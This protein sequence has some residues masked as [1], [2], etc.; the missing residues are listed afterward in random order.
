VCSILN[1]ADWEKLIVKMKRILEPMIDFLIEKINEKGEDMTIFEML[2]AANRIFVK[3]SKD[4]YA[5]IH[6]ILATHKLEPFLMALTTH[7]KTVIRVFDTHWWSKLGMTSFFNKNVIVF[8]KKAVR[9]FSTKNVIV[10]PKKTRFLAT[11]SKKKFMKTTSRQGYATK[12]RSCLSRMF[13]VVVAAFVRALIKH[14]KSEKSTQTEQAKLRSV[15]IA[16]TIG[17]FRLS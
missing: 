6:R 3:N 9:H 14:P 17:L 11:E 10:F 4:K 13:C 1:I 15:W 2:Q 7:P 8:P 5:I 16:E 12:I